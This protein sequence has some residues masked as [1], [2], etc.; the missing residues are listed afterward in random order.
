MLASNAA[1]WSELSA[2]AAQFVKLER[3]V[4][5]SSAWCVSVVIVVRLQVLR[6]LFRKFLVLGSRRGNWINDELF[7]SFLLFLFSRNSVW[8]LGGWRSMAQLLIT[9]QKLPPVEMTDDVLG[10]FTFGRTLHVLVIY[11]GTD[12]TIQCLDK[13]FPMKKKLLHF[14]ITLEIPEYCLIYIYCSNYYRI[15]LS[16]KKKSGLHLLL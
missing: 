6:N 8:W 9:K 11:Q 10:D 13:L 4:W 5:L 7:T 1:H 2:R 15:F 3:N 16:R 14:M 12:N